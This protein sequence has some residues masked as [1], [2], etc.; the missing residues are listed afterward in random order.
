M[1]STNTTRLGTEPT[2]KHAFGRALAHLKHPPTWL[3]PNT[4]ESSL[5][6]QEAQG[7][8]TPSWMEAVFFIPGRHMC[9][10]WGGGGHIT[11][12]RTPPTHLPTHA[13]PYPPPT[14]PPTHPPPPTPL[15]WLTLA[16]TPPTHHIVLSTDIY[17]F[18]HHVFFHI[19]VAYGS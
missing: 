3:I 19:W 14:H 9:D 7:S 2:S 16:P 1:P 4:P 15:Y 11:L 18:S 5:G 12:L 17:R 8:H 10:V 13:P 6:Q